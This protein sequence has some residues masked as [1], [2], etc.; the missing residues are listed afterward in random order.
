MTRQWFVGA[1]TKR[2]DLFPGETDG[3]WIEVKARLSW[4]EE[5]Q[6]ASS[7][8]RKMSGFTQR[9]FE[10]TPDMAEHAI[11][12]FL[13]WIVDWSLTDAKGKAAKLDRATVV[14]LHPTVAREIDR[15]LT[16]H[17][18]SVEAESAE[19]NAVTPG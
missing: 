7:A 19:K 16:E 4:G 9:D 8:F 18:E 2:L 17:I 14:N 3:G 11:N 1:E 6:L 12:R 10:V 5:Q 13:T 15:A